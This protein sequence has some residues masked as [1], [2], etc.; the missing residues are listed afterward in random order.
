MDHDHLYHA[1]RTPQF[2][3]KQKR[4]WPLHN[5]PTVNSYYIA[6]WGDIVEKQVAEIEKKGGVATVLMHPLCM[7]LSDEFKTA[8]RLFRFFSHYM[9]IWACEVGTYVKEG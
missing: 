9:T 4:N 3:E 6:E 1:H 8:E 5:D 7:Y 2:V